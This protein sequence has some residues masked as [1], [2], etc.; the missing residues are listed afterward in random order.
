[1]GMKISQNLLL[2]RILTYMNGTLFND[3]QWGQ[4]KIDLISF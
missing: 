3:S 4:L 2:S 1:M